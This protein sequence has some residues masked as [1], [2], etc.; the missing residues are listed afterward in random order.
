VS[1]GFE[2]HKSDEWTRREHG[3][4]TSVPIN[5]EDVRIINAAVVELPL[6]ERQTLQ[7][8]YV[9]GGRAPMTQACKLGIDRHGLLDLLLHART[10]L[11]NAGI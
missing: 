4:P 3:A 10:L 9:K 1:C 5:K 7:W 11:I 6:R 2:L 8:Y